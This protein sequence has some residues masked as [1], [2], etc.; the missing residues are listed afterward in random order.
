MIDPSV[1]PVT[2]REREHLRK[3]LQSPGW[4]VVQR[5]MSG[6]IEAMTDATIA[7]SKLSPLAYKDEIANRWAYITMAEQFRDQL[8]RGI[9]FELGLLQKSEP[10]QLPEAEILRRRAWNVLGM[11]G[12]IPDDFKYTRETTR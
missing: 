2:D 1:S 8:I 4:K 9:A 5:I 12:P 11:I 7:A 6:Y 3:M 10:E